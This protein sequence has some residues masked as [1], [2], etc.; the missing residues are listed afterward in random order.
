MTVEVFDN[1]VNWE[2]T[3]R[4]EAILFPRNGGSPVH[5]I[6]DF[7]PSNGACR[8]LCGLTEF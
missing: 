8:K 6:A 2:L 4:F 5:L 7:I 3:K 1:L